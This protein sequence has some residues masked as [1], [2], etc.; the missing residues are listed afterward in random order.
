MDD[1]L[2]VKKF[3]SLYQLF[4]KALCFELSQTS[5]PFHK[6]IQ[7]LIL[8]KLHYKIYVFRVLKS[9]LKLYNMLRAL[10]KLTTERTMNGNLGFELNESMILRLIPSI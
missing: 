3:S 10:S 9:P 2:R 5:S 7:R 6:L 8:T 4:D 1:L